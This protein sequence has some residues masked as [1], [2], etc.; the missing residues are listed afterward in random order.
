LAIVCE[1]KLS[2]LKINDYTLIFSESLDELQ[3]LVITSFKDVANKKLRKAHYDSDPYSE[4]KRKVRFFERFVC[5]L[6][7]KLSF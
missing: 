6:S 4:A 2:K 1:R 5:F 3:S 7:N